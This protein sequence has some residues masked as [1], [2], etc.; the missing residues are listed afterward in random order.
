[1]LV[2]PA[3]EHHLAARV[4]EERHDVVRA[5]H[6][7]EA[8]HQEGQG[9]DDEGAGAGLR[10]D[11]LD[12]ELHLLALAQQVGEVAE[13]VG[14]AA[15]GLDL[16]GDRDREEVHLGLVDDAGD[17]PERGVERLA[18]HDPLADRLEVAADR[19]VV[20]LADRA[21]ALDDRQ[22]RADAADDGVDRVGELLHEAVGAAAAAELH[23]AVDEE[24]PG[25]EAGD[26]TRRRTAGPRARSWRRRAGRRRPARRSRRWRPTSRGRRG[27]SW[28]GAAW[29]RAAG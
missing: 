8:E 26:Q 24:H 12:L 17:A 20:L 16:D 13:G 4:E 5:H 21:D 19:I 3:R 11:R 9:A 2:K 1:M 27:G 14:E 22:A 28:R 10:G 23:E 25:E 18:E 15:A 29:C 7:Q 6:H